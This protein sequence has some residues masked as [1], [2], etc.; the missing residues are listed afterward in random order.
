MAATTRNDGTALIGQ[1]RMGTGFT[2]RYIATKISN[3]P[4]D[5]TTSAIRVPL[6]LE[7]KRPKI[8]AITSSIWYVSEVN[9]FRIFPDAVVSKKLI[10]EPKTPLA[11]SS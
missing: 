6:I 9:R 4:G 10:G 5:M 8:G 3:L 1:P 2:Q 11:K 7:E